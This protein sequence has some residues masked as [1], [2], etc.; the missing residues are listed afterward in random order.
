MARAQIAAAVM[1]GL[2]VALPMAPTVAS[3]QVLKL[4]ELTTDQI[5][6]LDK[7]KTIVFIPGG[8]L[9]EHGPFLPVFTDGYRSEA[10][11]QELARAVVARPG[12]T[13]L[14][15]PTIPLGSGG[16]NELAGHFSFP[17]TYVVRSSTLR[18][19]F[20]DL[21]SELGEQGF[22]WIFV[23]HLHGA[24]SHHRALEEAGDYFH[25][26]YGGRMVHLYGLM[27]VLA[28]GAPGID[29]AQ[30]A[31]NGLDVHGGRTETSDVLFVRPDLVADG[32]R[33]APSFPG[34]DWDDLVR[35]ARAPG[36]PGYFGAPRQASAAEGQA[37]IQQRSKVAA[38]YMWRIVEGADLRD[39][40]R[41]TTTMAGSDAIAE[42][43]RAE[44]AHDRAR[45]ERFAAW[46]A[47][48]NKR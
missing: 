2:V 25:D 40:P 8:I 11:V 27:P 44:A 14:V 48:R 46:L 45:E 35:I 10:T 23:V 47:R 43:D 6:A 17:G 4:A 21:A 1:L 39:V 9:E 24:P 3:A 37:R 30:A 20:V 33:T 7:D 5:R 18:A 16:V 29:A 31:E 38:E 22:K 15:L 12:W 32:Y 42:V 36:W 26:T 13:A 41:W 34:A 28:A 19:V